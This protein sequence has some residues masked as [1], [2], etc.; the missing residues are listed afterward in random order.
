MSENSTAETTQAT[1]CCGSCGTSA[2]PADQAPAAVRATFEVHGMT[3]GHCVSA[4]TSEVSKLD[5]VAEVIVDLPSRRVTVDSNR[6]LD[7]AAVAA[8]IDEAGYDF[9]GRVAD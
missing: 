2:A 3:C 5:G 7:D 8:A 4:V 1:S 6:L 9:A